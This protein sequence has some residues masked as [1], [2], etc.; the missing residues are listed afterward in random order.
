MQE[1]RCIFLSKH[2]AR[3]SANP[4][5]APSTKFSRALLKQRV[6]LDP[7]KI[8]SEDP[9]S[10]GGLYSYTLSMTSG[11]LLYVR[12]MFEQERR[13]IF[14]K[15]ILLNSWAL[16]PSQAILR[17]FWHQYRGLVRNKHYL[18]IRIV[19]SFFKETIF[20]R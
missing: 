12:S 10:L 11:S 16:P 5:L 20:F 4:F 6:K 14:E 3:L 13:K 1:D 17:L 18:N 19:M 2:A 7:A 9:L 8:R 15:R